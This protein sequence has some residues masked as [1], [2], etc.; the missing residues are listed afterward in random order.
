M[1]EPIWVIEHKYDVANTSDAF[2]FYNQFTFCGWWPTQPTLEKLGV[3]LAALCGAPK[4]PGKRA[5]TALIKGEEKEI[6]KHNVYRL[7]RVENV[8]KLMVGEE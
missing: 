4:L 8:D 5:L 7:Y 2:L 1:T 6:Y 3:F